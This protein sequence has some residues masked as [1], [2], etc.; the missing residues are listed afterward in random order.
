[1]IRASF[2]TKSAPQ[3]IIA[4]FGRCWLPA[5]LT[6]HREP[7]AKSCVADQ[8]FRVH[9]P[10]FVTLYYGRTIHEQPP[11]NAVNARTEAELVEA[12]RSGDVE[13]FGELYQRHYE[14]AMGVAYGVLADRHLA[15]DAAQEAF[16]IAAR[17]LAGLR[18]AERFAPWICGIARRVASQMAR[19]RRE[20]NTL[21][22]SEAAPS[23]HDGPHPSDLVRQAVLELPDRSREVVVLHYFTGLSHKE[24][25]ASLGVS[26]EAVHGRL[27]RARRML[28]ERLTGNGMGEIEL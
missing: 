14:P 20:R 18:N 17:Q 19:S 27:V 4:N 15:E 5:I 3:S 28:A 11:W 12:A 26:P 16:V 6:H 7:T 8:F 22:D 21:D 24:I 9:Y 23:V 2:T 13:S 25:A 1:M 10:P